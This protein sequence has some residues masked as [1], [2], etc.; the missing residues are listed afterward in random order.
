MVQIV[1]NW[2]DIEGRVDQVAPAPDDP[3]MVAVSV[4]LDMADDVEGFRNLLADSRGSVV[5]VLL[6]SD[7]ASERGLVPGTR[8]VARAR[9]SGPDR[10]F[11]HPEH[12][13]VRTT[14]G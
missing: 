6:R 2:A 8:L 10:T 9:R 3:S 7:I 4:A 12:V 1:E 11:V 5:T 14:P 13:E